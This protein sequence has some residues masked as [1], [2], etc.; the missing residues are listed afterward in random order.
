MKKLKITLY[1]LLAGTVAITTSSCKKFLDVNKNPNAPEV[2][3]P[4][5]LLTAAQVN[6]AFTQGGDISRY[7]SVFNQQVKG[8]TRQF[9]SYNQYIMSSEDFGN[10]WGNLYDGTM[11]DLVQIQKIADENGYK[12]YS[13]VSKV[14][15]AYSLA[16]ATDMWGDVPYTEAFVGS[17]KLQPKYD[18]QED[19][20]ATIIKLLMDAK[21]DLA[22][23][24]ASAGGLRPGSDDLVFGGNISKWTKMANSLMARNWLHLVKRKP[25][26]AIQGMSDAITAG[27]MASISDD[28]KVAFV[29][30]PTNASPWY[31]YISARDDIGYKSWLTDT[32][33]GLGDPRFLK[34]VDTDGGTYGLGAHYSDAASAVELMTYSEYKFIEAE[35]HMLKATPDTAAANAAY[36][37]AV[38]ASFTNAGA[39]GA[40]SYL[41]NMKVNLI[42]LSN[43]DRLTRIRF[44]KYIALYLHPEAFNNWRLTGIPGIVPTNGASIPRRFIYSQDELSYNGAN[45]PTGTSLFSKVWWDN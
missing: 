37:A 21:T 25:V 32:M 30:S 44:Q 20:Y 40:T 12:H 22:T 41:A 34:Y 14:L 13:G 4:A 19:V 3:T 11:M 43:S 26:Q 8:A 7:T 15:M 39:S 9:A 1:L 35:F 2:V 45:V 27:G 16:L 31:Q 38:A 18:K 42:G 33:M 17:D 10:A 24:V 36:D 6:L 23:P 28:A 29:N 5:V